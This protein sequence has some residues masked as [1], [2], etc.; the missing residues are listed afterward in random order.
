MINVFHTV[1]FEGITKM[2]R[3]SDR[4]KV[5]QNGKTIA[6]LGQWLKF[7]KSYNTLNTPILGAIAGQ[8]FIGIDIDNSLMFNGLISLLTDTKDDDK[9]LPAYVAMS[10]PADANKGGHILFSWEKTEEHIKTLLIQLTAQF[11]KA[12]IDIQMNNKLIYL[13][14][15]ENTTKKL[16]TPPI[17]DLDQLTP[18]SA[19]VLVYLQSH[20]DMKSITQQSQNVLD[21]PETFFGYLLNST[22]TPGI[23]KALTPRATFPDVVLMDDIPKGSATEWLLKVRK[24]LQVDKTVS[25][26][27]FGATIRYLNSLWSHPRGPSKQ[28][29][30]DIDRDVRSIAFKFDDTWETNG[31]TF[32]NSIGH[33]IGVYYAHK[34]DV[35]VQH[36]TVTDEV[37]SYVSSSKCIDSIAAI[38]Q[39]KAKMKKDGLLKKTQ[40]ITLVDT[41]EEKPRLSQPDPDYL[42]IFNL[43][44]PSEGTRLVKL[45]E[46][47]GEY[48]EPVAILAFLKHLIP[49]DDNRVRLMKFLAHKH[50]TY[51]PSPLY[52]VFA[53]VGGAGKG[54]IVN[55]ILKY[56]SGE[57]RMMSDDLQGITNNFNEHLATID[58]LEIEEAGEGYSKR[59]SQQ[60]VAELKKLTGSPYLTIEGKGA[61]KKKI[62]HYITPIISSNLQTKLITS[63]TAG[64][65]R[66]VLLR[67]PVKLITA[68]DNG[69]LGLKHI[70][71][72]RDLYQMMEAE[73]PH[74]AYYISNL[75]PIAYGDYT[76]NTSWK[77]EDYKDYVESS[78]TITDILVQAAEDRDLDK[79]VEVLGN[80]NIAD[81]SIDQLFAASRGG[82]ARALIYWTQA[83]RDAGFL[84]LQ[85]IMEGSDMFVG[86]PKFLLKEYKTRRTVQVGSNK[87]VAIQVIEFPDAYENRTDMVTIDHGE[88]EL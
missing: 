21:A 37:E 43:Y 66:L 22:L 68:I 73:L 34:D 29:E 59:E 1:P 35:W 72:T 25:E 57:Q 27:I 77:S 61:M 56:L 84:S 87:T 64:D 63:T 79:L 10:M 65:R 53:G 67:N 44:T 54:I 76:D 75:D 13:A 46:T 9:D 12:K 14:T 16:M 38:H 30:Q 50:R 52:F 83:T 45:K 71:D 17:T 4:V 58:Y 5:D 39:K 62:R 80:A 6:P 19:E 36:N 85:E 31:L 18:L 78:M 26:E 8:D 2:V 82:P 28:L 88:T 33:T 86:N 47:I 55:L 40:P 81:E 24:K 74:F 60:L 7:T 49:H 48:R 42:P 51:E 32:P 23:V 3:N 41:P 70:K 69:T 20:L 15:P 11:G